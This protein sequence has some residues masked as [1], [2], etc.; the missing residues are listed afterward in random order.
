MSPA[1]RRTSVQVTRE[2][3]IGCRRNEQLTRAI[4]TGLQKTP[5]HFP[6]RTGPWTSKQCTKVNEPLRRE[7]ERRGLITWTSVRS[8]GI[9]RQGLRGGVGESRAELGGCGRRP[10]RLERYSLRQ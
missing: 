2:S 8:Q 5:G 4:R 7:L 6:A 3:P 10:P 9:T 1:V